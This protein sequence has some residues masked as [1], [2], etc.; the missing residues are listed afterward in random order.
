MCAACFRAA[1]FRALISEEARNGNAAPS[2]EP[3]NLR[4]ARTVQSSAAADEASLES[5]VEKY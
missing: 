1:S 2:V 3:E 4:K 5:D